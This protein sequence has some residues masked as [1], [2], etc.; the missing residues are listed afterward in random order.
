MATREQIL[1]ALRGGV[2]ESD[3]VDLGGGVAVTLRPVSVGAEQDCLIRARRAA[4]EA[5]IEPEYRDAW[6]E[7]RHALEMIAGALAHEGL[8]VTDLSE[9]CTTPVLARLIA[10]MVETQSGVRASDRTLSEVRDAVGEP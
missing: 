3:P 4:A 1:S 2:I 5:G 10:A 6:V 8:T 7:N 9:H